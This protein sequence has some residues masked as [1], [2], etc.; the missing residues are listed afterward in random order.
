MGE[1][2]AAEGA[3]GGLLEGLGFSAR[4]T[5]FGEESRGLRFQAIVLLFEDGALEEFVDALARGAIALGG[6]NV[7]VDLGIDHKAL[8]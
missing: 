2:V 6:V 1:S 4:A 3:Q 8:R 5:S 7:F